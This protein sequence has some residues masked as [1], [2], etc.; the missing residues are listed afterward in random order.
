MSLISSYNMYPVLSA[1]TSVQPLPPRLLIPSAPSPRAGMDD[2]EGPPGGAPLTTRRPIRIA[3]GSPHNPFPSQ[4]T[5]TPI[6][7][8]R[9]ASP[10]Q[11]D[12]L[13]V[14]QVI[15]ASPRQQDDIPVAQ[16]TPTTPLQKVLLVATVG[17]AALS[18]IPP[19][20][21]AGSLALR[22][23]AL[24]S[25]ILN[26]EETWAKNDTLGSILNYFKVA[27]VTF[28]IV[29]LVA[30]SPMLMVA[31][32]AAD[33]GFQAIQMARCIYKGEYSKALIH[34]GVIVID[35]LAL[36]G[37]VTGS[38]QLMVAA[39]AVSAVGMLILFAES[40]GSLEAFS[41]FALAIIGGVAAGTIGN[42]N[43]LQEP[44]GQKTT[45]FDYDGNGRVIGQ[46]VVYE[47]TYSQDHQA[48]TTLSPELFPTV[49]VGGP[50]I[51]T[52]IVK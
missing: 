5:I 10:R 24:L 37:I 29:A 9:S 6:A 7:S 22:G 2:V 16:E 15:P 21:L 4:R 3:S 13:P 28:G 30:A 20:R 47:R 44:D 18:L 27:V 33:I 23:I 34:F 1:P 42:T 48:P 14:A 51:V 25:S 32:L 43:I 35:S 11:Q 39:A 50:A 26:S 40:K 12:R 38:W 19:F 45:V 17:C 41:Y 31:S 8:A 52:N 36:A 49:P 46:H